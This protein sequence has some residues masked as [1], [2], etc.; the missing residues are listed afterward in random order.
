MKGWKT[1]AFALAVA[2]LPFFASAEMAT[3][4][5]ENLPNHVVSSLMPGAWEC[6]FFLAV[7]VVLALLLT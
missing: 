4:V 1:L 5:A 2:I 7:L 3:F 6:L